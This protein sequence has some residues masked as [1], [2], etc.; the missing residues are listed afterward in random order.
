[1]PTAFPP[2]GAYNDRPVAGSA[3]LSTLTVAQIHPW[4][5]NEW[6]PLAEL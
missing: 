5:D 1:M 2:S 4:I 6:G 3:A